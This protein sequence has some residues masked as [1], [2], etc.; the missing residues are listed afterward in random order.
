MEVSKEKKKLLSWLPSW[1]AYRKQMYL[2]KIHCRWSHIVHRF[3][4]NC[5]NVQPF[6]EHQLHYS[7]ADETHLPLTDCSLWETS[8][9]WPPPQWEL[10][11]V[12]VKLCVCLCVGVLC[13]YCV[14]TVQLFLKCVWVLFHCLLLLTGVQHQK[15]PDLSLTQKLNLCSKAGR[16]FAKKVYRLKIRTECN[17][18][19]VCSFYLNPEAAFQE[20]RCMWCYFF[21]ISLKHST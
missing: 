11:S 1:H 18:K 13:L 21:F 2:I 9:P 15:L 17:T 7:T 10:S 20:W 4:R 12:E 5:K 3:A 8:K 19:S 6:Y 16:A 14:W